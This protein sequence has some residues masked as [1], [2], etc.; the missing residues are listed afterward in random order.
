MKYNRFLEGGH[1]AKKVINFEV[2]KLEYLFYYGRLKEGITRFLSISDFLELKCA[3]KYF[4]HTLQ[5][6]ES[7]FLVRSL[8][9]AHDQK[10]SAESINMKHYE[11]VM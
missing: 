5:K 3:S 10:Q 4:K 8:K 2:M 1:E 9:W 6:E 11:R 7:R